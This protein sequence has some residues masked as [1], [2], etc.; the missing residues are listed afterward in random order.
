MSDAGFRYSGKGKRT[1][2]MKVFDVFGCDTSTV[3]EVEV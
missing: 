3:L 1:I 2:C